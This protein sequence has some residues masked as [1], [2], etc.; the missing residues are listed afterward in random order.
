VNFKNRVL[1]LIESY[2]KHQQQNPLAIEF[3]VPLLTLVRT[4]QTKQLADRGANIIQQFCGRCKGNNV[5][6]LRDAQIADA[7]QILQSIHNEACLESSNAHSTNAS[8]ASILLIRTLLHA[9]PTYLEPVVQIYAGTRM[10]QLS[11]KNCRVLPG[12]FTDWNNWCQSARGK[13]SK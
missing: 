9:D 6:E 7:K 10:R 4:S 3:V 8:Q 12:F 2:L 13:F 5:P 11:E 1:D